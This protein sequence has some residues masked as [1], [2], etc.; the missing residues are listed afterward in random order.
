MRKIG[1]GL[2]CI[3]LALV[4]LALPQSAPAQ[5]VGPPNEI[6]CNKH[7]VLQAVGATSIQ[8]ILPG[9]AGQSI[10]ICG[11]MWNVGAAASTAA[12]YVGTGTNC[13]T[14]QLPVT[15][16]LTLPANSTVVVKSGSGSFS[17]AQGNQ[18]CYVITGTGPTAGLIFYAQF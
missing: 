13:N 10:T 4:G 16:I 3:V 6:V 9:V 12:L 7:L 5:P 8:Q 18:L 1:F 11:F 15:P 2:L 17:S 14:N